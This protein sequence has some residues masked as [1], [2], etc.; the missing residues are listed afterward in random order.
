MSIPDTR[1]VLLPRSTGLFYAL[2]ALMRQHKRRSRRDGTRNSHSQNNAT[3]GPA[4]VDITLGYPGA[5]R[6][7][8]SSVLKKSANSTTTTTTTTTTTL[9]P[10]PKSF[11][12]DWTWPEEHYPLTRVWFAQ[13]P[14]PAI[15]VHVRAFKLDDI[16]GIRSRRRVRS[17]A[18]SVQTDNDELEDEDDEHD[19]DLVVARKEF[20]EWLIARWRDKDELMID[21]AHHGSF[22]PRSTNS[23]SNSMVNA[24]G[25]ADGDGDEPNGDHTCRRGLDSAVEWPLRLRRAHEHFEPFALVLIVVI[26]VLVFNWHSSSTISAI[27]TAGREIDPRVDAVA[28]TV[29]KA[30]CQK[31]T[32]ATV[33]TTTTVRALMGGHGQEL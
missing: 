25:D 22:E 23:G 20:D 19:G 3:T 5:V 17:Q 4:L 21:F 7:L 18:G 14:P 31:A 26:L 2:R 11:P 9:E 1:Q 16:P 6:P 12:D 29:V 24:D 30:C 15:H 8:P 10:D 13:E 28:S 33:T 27:G 32:Q